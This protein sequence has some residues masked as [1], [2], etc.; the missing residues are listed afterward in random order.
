[1]AEPQKQ[2]DDLQKIISAKR[3]SIQEM[4]K[5]ISNTL[6][7]LISD[8]CE[9][10]GIRA[11]VPGKKQCGRCI[12]LWHRQQNLSAKKVLKIL[13]SLVGE[14][15]IKADLGHIE[16]KDQLLN[17][18]SNSLF[19][20]GDIGA[21]KT[22]AM[23]ALIKHYLS[24]GYSCER[25]NFDDFCCRVRSTM[26]LSSK[27]T[28]YDLIQQMVEVDKLF[29]DD[30]GLRSKQ[31]TDFAYV[32]LYAILNKRIEKQ[33]PTYIS[34]NKNIERLTEAFDSRIASRLKLFVEI[35]MSGKD[36]RI[37]G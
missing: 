14:E 23:A 37:S 7:G 33:L 24:G 29:I 22:Y 30:I 9:R 28:E 1:M 13:T 20:W 18:G 17:L 11:V 25:V 32:T 34:T 2:E 10:C 27:T 6:Q 26:T 8:K 3:L 12:E 5:R 19:L 21:G 16:I 35:K 31:E 15:Y 36:K 4:A